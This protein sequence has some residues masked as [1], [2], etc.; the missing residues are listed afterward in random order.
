M[1]YQ[2]EECLFYSSVAVQLPPHELS[3]VSGG[4]Q[5]GRLAQVSPPFSVDVFLMFVPEKKEIHLF[6][7]DKCYH[8]NK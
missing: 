4:C 2:R 5:G 6:H 3:S 7:V 8:L 1:F